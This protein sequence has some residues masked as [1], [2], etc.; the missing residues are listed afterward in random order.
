MPRKL[1]HV[2]T[3]VLNA[4]VRRN[5]IKPILG[6]LMEHEEWPILMGELEGRRPPHRVGVP[7]PEVIDVVAERQSER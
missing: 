6:H 1:P 2:D 3:N 5:G 7:L 4:L